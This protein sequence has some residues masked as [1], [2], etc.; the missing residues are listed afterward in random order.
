MRRT[1]LYTTRNVIPSV[2]NGVE[3]F[4]STEVDAGFDAVDSIVYAS[5]VLV[6]RFFGVVVSANSR[7][8]L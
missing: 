2:I 6:R 5:E 8:V 4:D 3:S 1:W 7:S